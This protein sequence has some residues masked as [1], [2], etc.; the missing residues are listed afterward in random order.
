MRQ[1]ELQDEEERMQKRQDVSSSSSIVRSGEG[2]GEVEYSAVAGLCSIPNQNDNCFTCQYAIYICIYIN[3]VLTL[4]QLHICDGCFSTP[5]CST[6]PSFACP[7]AYM[8]I[9]YLSLHS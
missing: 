5:I 4:A 8:H 9:L 3:C 1:Q 7:Y 6:E 2:E